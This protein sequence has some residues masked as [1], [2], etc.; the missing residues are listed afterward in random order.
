M[1]FVGKKPLAISLAGVLLSMMAV[2]VHAQTVKLGA[3]VNGQVT[4]LSVKEGDSVQKGQALL[5]I[6]ARA[7]QAQMA[8]IKANL[9]LAEIELKD[10]KTDFEAEKALFDQNATAKRRF[11]GVQLTN[12]RAK[13]RVDLLKA[14]LA[15]LTAL[16]DYH[17]IRAPVSGKISQL[18]VSLGDTVFKEHQPL[19]QIEV[20]P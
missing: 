16:Q 9:R 6:D 18:S 7:L 13:A 3:L 19:L 2:S 4:Q 20:S 8:Q 5:E 1:S 11:D 15:E 17:T 10:A 14:E 12:D